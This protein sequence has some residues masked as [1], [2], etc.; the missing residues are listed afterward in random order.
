[1]FSSRYLHQAQALGHVRFNERGDLRCGDL[2]AVGEQAMQQHPA[3]ILLYPLGIATRQK[4]DGYRID[5]M[6]LLIG[7]AATVA[8]RDD[9]H[10]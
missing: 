3:A 4:I 1:M 2:Q 7:V 10:Q 6:H 5:P 9:E 8:N